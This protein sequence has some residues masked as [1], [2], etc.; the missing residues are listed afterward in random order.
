MSEVE[1]QR[2]KPVLDDR[3]QRRSLATV[4]HVVCVMSC[5]DHHMLN[6]AADNISATQELV[7]RHTRVDQDDA[8]SVL[9]DHRCLS[10]SLHSLH[11]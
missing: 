9:V 3:S 10:D 11:C 4:T 7:E 1:N 8:E 2:R 6:T 5:S